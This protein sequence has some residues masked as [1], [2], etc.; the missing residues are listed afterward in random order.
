[1]SLPLSYTSQT[2]FVMHYSETLCDTIELTHKNLPF[3]SNIECGTLMFHEVESMRYT[4]NVLDSV[5]LVNPNIDNEEKTN[6]NIYYRV[7][8]GE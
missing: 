7:T 6:F 1:M 4:T 2:T 3:V 5:V 8:D